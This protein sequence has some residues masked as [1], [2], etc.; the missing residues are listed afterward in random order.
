MFIVSLGVNYICFKCGQK[1]G[2]QNERKRLKIEFSEDTQAI[3][4]QHYHNEDENIGLE[5]IAE[6]PGP[7]AGQISN[8]TH[9]YA[10]YD[11]IKDQRQRMQDSQ[12]RKEGGYLTPVFQEP[13]RSQPPARSGGN[14]YVSP[15]TAAKQAS[16]QR[17]KNDSPSPP[18][19]GGYLSPLR[20]AKDAAARLLSGNSD[21]SSNKSD[22]SDKSRKYQNEPPRK[23]PPK[24]APLYEAIKDASIIQ[25]HPYIDLQTSMS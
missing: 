24:T 14:G 1:S 22:K 12:R 10:A 18:G 21:S 4:V 15:V 13:S 6:H 20:E 5:R 2:A 11:E 9:E 7:S 8:P 19:N 17:N 3:N 16:G 23:S 25:E